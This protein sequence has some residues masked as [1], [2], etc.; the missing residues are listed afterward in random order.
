MAD[1]AD[2][3]QSQVALAKETAAA[4]AGVTATALQVIPITSESLKSSQT[5]IVDDAVT[6]DRQYSD[7]KV[8]G[9]NSGGGL[10]MNM[11]WSEFDNLL[12][13]LF[14]STWADDPTDVVNTTEYLYNGLVKDEYLIEKRL[15][16][17]HDDGKTWNHFIRMYNQRI[18]SGTIDIKPKG[19]VSL[20]LNFVGKGVDSAQAD[21]NADVNAGKIASVASY[22][23]PTSAAL[24][25]GSNSIAS[26]VLKDSTD[27]DISAVFQGISINIDNQLR[28]DD[29]VGSIYAAGIGAGRFKCTVDADIY[30]KDF[31]VMSDF[32]SDKSMKLS[33]IVD[34]PT[35]DTFELMLNNLK[36]QEEDT[37]I[38]GADATLV[39]KVK[40]QAFPFDHTFNG[41]TTSVTAVI[42]RVITV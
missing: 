1:F 26:A 36:V 20:G 23:A 22:T 2:T 3:S 42:K 30:F 21:A 12:A 4:V 32:L 31:K 15:K 16:A 33:V 14:G 11:K 9:G 13:S 25:D 6:A 34:G 39:Q 37:N 41:N 5:A 38:S 7:S 27:T 19:Y 28:E 35:G 40:F 24:I 18:A 29:A 8:V 10:S 17:V